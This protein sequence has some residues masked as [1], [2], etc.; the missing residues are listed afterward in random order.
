ML[1]RCATA[2][3]VITCLQGLSTDARA[4]LGGLGGFV[5]GKGKEKEE[6]R[7]I[8][9]LDIQSDSSDYDEI[10][11][12]AKASGNVIVKYG[13]DITIEAGQVEY[14]KSS[15]K[16]YARDNVRV[17]RN[18][19]TID[20]EEIIYDTKTG[21]LTTSKLRSALEPI[22]FTSESIARPSEDSGGPITL[23]NSTFTTH[24][25]SDPNYRVQVKKLTVY[26]DDRIVMEG[27]KVF[28]GD[29]PLVW[30]P[31]YVQ[32]LNDELG[33]YFTPGWNSAWGGFLLNRYGFM[34]GDNVLA[35]A[36]LDVRTERGVAGGV[37]FK[38]QKF[39]DN[40]NIG[41]LNLY[42][43]EDSNPQRRFNGQNRLDDV[44]PSRYRVNFQ[45]RVYF[46]GSDDETFYLDFDI[47][48]LSDSF[49]YEDFFPSEFRVDPR[50]DNVINLAKTFD[51]GEVSLTSRFQLNDFF[52][53]DTRN[54]LAV[55]IIRTP[56]GE[57]GFFY[58]G[59]TTYGVID[60]EFNQTDLIADPIAG[61]NRFQTYHEF[62]F[63]TQLG[64]FLNVVPRAGAGYANYSDFD[65]AGLNDFDSTT[66][67]AGVD[68]SFK[69]SK[70]SPNVVN[71]ALGINGLLHVVR[72]YMN[73]SLVRTDEID[74]AFRSIDRRAP[75]TRL[76]PIDLPLYTAVDE[77]RDW[78][79]ARFGVSNRW[80]TKR[81]GQSYEWLT[82]NNY[83]DYY[84]QDPEF[85]R[86]FSNFYTEIDWRPVPWL[87]AGTTAQL[88]L[89][90]NQLDFTEVNS[91]VSF[92]P[93]DWFRFG[94]GHYFLTDHPTLPDSDL[95]SLTT[96][97]RLSDDW[98]FSTS[99][100][101][102]SDDNT[103]EYQQYT[104]HKDLASWTASVGAIVRD[105]RD[106][107]NE[108]GVLLS[109]TLKAFPRVSLP[110]DF[111]PGGLGPEEDL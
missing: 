88:P 108:Y 22:F 93:T 100:R 8:V 15:G 84:A 31:F 69:M 1:R 90:E 78:Q 24:D 70:S 6:V 83:F 89:F 52:Q 79:V 63:P 99:H 25:S 102:E 5:F 29:V 50:P 60:E 96:Y 64:G 91:L 19:E 58:E 56:I 106:G 54:E 33:F 42:Y 80:I 7:E 55:D 18:G 23:M 36:H 74:G 87:S 110:V 61:Y 17:F 85:N 57:S 75:S 51:Q 20:A 77:L 59:M 38:D 48:R 40:D 39:K 2:L 71:K 47:N 111:Q 98:G 62:L 92:M 81:D 26:P 44:D 4:Q 12:I 103:L 68:V 3:V 95:Y 43:T 53:T 94:V 11:G 65:L 104:V 35:K 14:H 16:I 13:D 107:E 105:N 86:D 101:F 72:P 67:H 9:N 37:E 76:R 97:T 34:V 82:L 66:T 41:I 10:L 109:L 30:L 49:I 32:P 45:Q 21:E 28:V 73:Y 46:P 27:A